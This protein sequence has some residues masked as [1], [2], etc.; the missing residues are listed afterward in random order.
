MTKKK[1]KTIAFLTGLCLIAVTLFFG[2]ALINVHT[3]AD[4][5]SISLSDVV[6]ENSYDI[7]T[8]LSIPKVTETFNG[9][10]VE[11]K[12]IVRYPDGNAYETKNPTLSQA[13]KYTVDFLFSKDGELLKSERKDFVVYN[14][15]FSFENSR[16]S[17]TYD[18]T[19]NVPGLKVSLASG[20][21]MTFNRVIDLTGLTAEDYLISAYVLPSVEGTLEFSEFSITLTDIV[22]ESKS[23]KILAEDCGWDEY[24]GWARAG[25]NGRYVG[26]ELTSWNDIIHSEEYGA[27]FSFSFRGLSKRSSLLTF[28]LNMATYEVYAR[29]TKVVDL[30]SSTY[31]PNGLWEGFTNNQVKMSVSVSGNLSAMASFV[32]TDVIQT[33]LTADYIDQELYSEIKIDSPETMLQGLVGESYAIPSA[34]AYL[35]GTKSR[36]YTSVFYNYYDLENRVNVDC[37][38]GRFKTPKEGLYTIEYKVYNEFGNYTTELVD[39]YVG[40][41]L[42]SAILMVDNELATKFGYSGSLI[43]IADY[44]TSGDGLELNTVITVERDGVQKNVFNKGF[45]ADSQGEYVVKY[46]TTDHVGRIVEESYTVTV[47]DGEYPVFV[48]EPALPDFYLGGYDYV[49]P[50]L[51]AVYY[52]TGEKVVANVRYKVDDGEYTEAL[53]GEKT[54]INCEGTTGILYVQ[55]YVK[56]GNEIVSELTMEREIRKVYDG[57][58]M[59]MSVFFEKSEGIEVEKNENGYSFTAQKDGTIRFIKEQ[60]AQNFSFQ[61]KFDKNNNAWENVTIYLTDSENLDERIAIRFKNNSEKLVMSFGETGEYVE[62]YGSMSFSY[63]ESSKAVIYNNINCYARRTVNGQTFNGFSSGL[64]YFEMEIEGVTNASVIDFSRFNGQMLNSVI[65]FDTTRPKIV[66]SGSFGGKYT[67]GET[68]TIARAIACDIFD[69]NIDSYVTVFS[70]S[71]QVVTSVDGIK[72]DKVDFTRDY[73]IL[74]EEIGEYIVE[75]AAK[76][77]YDSKMQTIRAKITAI[78]QNEIPVVTLYGEIVSQAFVGDTIS[79][80]EAIS[81]DVDGGELEVIRVV[82]TPALDR[83]VITDDYDSFVV[84]QA[85]TYTILYHTVN[86]DGEPAYVRFVLDVD[87]R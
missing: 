37:S 28:S 65:T 26:H 38:N 43:K 47:T 83:L 80:P 13:G 61:L 18:E 12:V 25:F 22:D 51:N 9:E 78:K 46:T 33:D 35:N 77:K 7:N 41:S 15:V 34:T 8:E 5:T 63:A 59:D 87:K 4:E 36:V 56:L 75:Y 71:G 31:F 23:I 19:L 55:Y 69:P 24:R 2:G 6:F 48:E 82:I 29:Q 16:S 86:S 45:I 30:N 42:P 73:E 32:L 79:I 85:G 66:V 81:Y 64:I 70:A 60:I 39:V 57:N 10:S 72:L 74:I 58:V 62:D 3:F 17:A 49:F 21:T 20:D 44:A 52:G 53:S 84:H 14:D 76:G 50:T 68:V 1:N 54:T 27:P 11:A 67:L 40:E